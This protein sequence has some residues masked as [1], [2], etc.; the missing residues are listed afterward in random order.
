MAKRLQPL[1]SRFGIDVR[2]DIWVVVRPI[3]GAAG[4]YVNGNVIRIS[5][6]TANV[7]D[8]RIAGGTAA[9]EVAHIVQHHILGD[10]VVNL[11]QYF[12]DQ[13]WGRSR[14]GLKPGMDVPIDRVNP[15]SGEY[16]LEGL[17]DRFADEIFESE[18]W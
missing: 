13:S 7:A 1:F 9:H 10:D 16:A 3:P 14:Y 5:D 8:Q 11:F 2:R 12:E 18:A 15:V 6:A 17:A 4:E